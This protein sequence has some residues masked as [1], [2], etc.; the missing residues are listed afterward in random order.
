LVRYPTYRRGFLSTPLVG[1]RTHER[2][3]TTMR[4]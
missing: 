4:D 2:I 1:W 3:L